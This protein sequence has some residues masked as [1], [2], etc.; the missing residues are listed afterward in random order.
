MTTAEPVTI[1]PTRSGAAQFA[2]N[3]EP[4]EGGGLVLMP[5]GELDMAAAPALRGRIAEA[6]DAGVTRLVVGLCLVSFMDS[7]ALA[8]L[9]SARR[10]MGDGVRMAV[11][12]PSGSYTRLLF[13]AAGHPR[14]LELF[15]TYDEAVR[16]VARQA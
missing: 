13:D 4:L 8:A 3:E 11:V 7:V 12:V 6:V 14:S 16:Y 2:L 15:E 1:D 9:L 10:G 5:W